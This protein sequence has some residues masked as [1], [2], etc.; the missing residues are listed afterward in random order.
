MLSL[1]VAEG[2]FRCPRTL[3]VSGLTPLDSVKPEARPASSSDRMEASRAD[4]PS[5]FGGSEGG[6]GEKPVLGGR[7]EALML[8]VRTGSPGEVV[9]KT[10]LP[11]FSKP[12]SFISLWS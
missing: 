12:S 7:G 3:T 11:A 10:A 6:R 1:F 2:R 8:G 5:S 4:G 9:C